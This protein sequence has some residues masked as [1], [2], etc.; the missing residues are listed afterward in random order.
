M[1]Q[2]P[3]KDCAVRT[4]PGYGKLKLSPGRVSKQKV[5]GCTSENGDRLTKRLMTWPCAGWKI[6]SRIGKRRDGD[7]PCGTFAGRLDPSIADVRMFS[8]RIF[9]ATNWTG[10]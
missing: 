4:Q 6:A 10:R 3:L 8:T 5:W 1:L 9:T 7:G 2:S